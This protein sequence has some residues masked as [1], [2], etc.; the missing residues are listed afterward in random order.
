[1]LPSLIAFSSFS[2]LSGTRGF[3]LVELSVV[4]ALLAILAVMIVSFTSLTSLRTKQ[5]TARTDCMDAFSAYR[6]AVTDGFAEMD[7]SDTFSFRVENGVLV[8]GTE[9]FAPDADRIDGI[10]AE[11]NDTLLRI[12]ITNDTLSL[13]ES[14]VIASHCGATFTAGGGE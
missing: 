1:M 14:F 7:K 2:F 4:M 12:T 6:T 10:T 13:T 5:A 9:T 3:T 11:T 8:I